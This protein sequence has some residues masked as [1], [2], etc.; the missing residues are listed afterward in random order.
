MRILTMVTPQSICRWELPSQRVS[1]K[2]EVQGGYRNCFWHRDGK[3]V[4]AGTSRSEANSKMKLVAIA[5]ATVEGTLLGSISVY[6]MAGSHLV[7]RSAGTAP[8]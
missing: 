2:P 3:V 5:I 7:D 4:E 8:L 1:G 6:M